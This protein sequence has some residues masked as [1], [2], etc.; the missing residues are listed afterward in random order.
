M[1]ILFKGFLTWEYR[2]ASKIRE[3]NPVKECFTESKSKNNYMAI[4]NIKIQILVLC[5][6]IMSSCKND[7]LDVV[8]DNVATIDNAF[9]NRIEAEKFLFTCY[10]Y[11]P[12][13]SDIYVNPAILAGDEFWTY[14][15]ITSLSRL[16]VD[17]QQ[18]ARGNQ[19]IVD[20]FLNYWDGNRGGQPLFRALRDCNIFLDNVDKVVD[21]DPV[22]KTRWIGEVQFLKAYYHFYLL[23]MYGP[24]HVIDKNI[25]ISASTEEVRVRRDP[26]DKVV[27]YI[28]ALLDSAATNLPSKIANRSSELGHATKPAALSL[29]AKTLVMAASPLFNGNSDYGQLKNADGSQLFNTQY[30]AEKW[31]QAAKA[32]KEAITECETAGLKLYEFNS[33]LVNIPDTLKR[34]MTIRNSVTEPWNAELIW[35]YSN[36]QLGRI[37]TQAMPRLDP[38][39]TTNESALGQLAPTLKMAELFYT[40]NGVPITEDKEWDYA[41]RYSLKKAE[42]NDKNYILNGYTTAY[43]H[44][45]R[46]ARFYADMAFDGS[47]WYMQNRTWDVKAK[48]G[49]AQSRKSA[50]GYSITGYFTKKLVNWKFVIQDG[51]AYTTEL[52]PWPMIRLADLYLLYAEAL[53]ESGKPYAEA[54]EYLNKVRSRSGL[55]TVENSWT[56][57]S[58]NPTKFTTKE[59][60]REIIHRERAIELAFEG[61]RFWDLRRWKE[62]SAALNASVAGWDIEQAEEAAYYRPKLLYSQKFIAPRDYF[63]PIREHD[64]IVNPNILQNQGW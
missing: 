36:S 52:Y 3:I 50:F 64:I 12:N 53:N 37:Q 54:L 15:P 26:V 56:N 42:G 51:Q 57:F 34:Q 23:R 30:D 38:G 14:W 62:A 43:L 20:P 17:P 6:A 44:F 63:W 59:G 48:L 31:V 58:T 33:S 29:K 46:E 18:I 8:P 19:N 10:S 16:P 24:I 13:E 39:R 1:G 27:N 7:F 35:G 49:Q 22:M 21:L 5:M 32:C 47:I 11:L 45:N 4:R 9:T 55:P 41:E 60:L 40:E 2:L 28:V 25:P 61:Q